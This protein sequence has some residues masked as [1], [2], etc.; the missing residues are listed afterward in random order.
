MPREFTC[1][2]LDLVDNGVVNAAEVLG[3]FLSHVSEDVVKD[4]CL[5]GSYCELFEDEE[6]EG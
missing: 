1:K 5:N 3:Q 6:A 4:F 2:L